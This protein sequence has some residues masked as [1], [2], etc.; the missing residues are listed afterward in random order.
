LA[1]LT[2]RSILA[3]M[4]P[5]SKPMHLWKRKHRAMELPF[6][7]FPIVVLLSRHPPNYY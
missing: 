1:H 6:F 4:I 7:S 3:L 2:N 5:A